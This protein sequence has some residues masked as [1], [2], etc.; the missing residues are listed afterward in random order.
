MYKS[1]Q[2][3]IFTEE[4]FNEL[5]EFEKAEIERRAAQNAEIVETLATG[6]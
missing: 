6:R 4:D 5:T 1:E 3:I 2:E